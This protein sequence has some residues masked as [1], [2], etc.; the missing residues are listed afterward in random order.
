MN[1]YHVA[2]GR[3]IDGFDVLD[4]IESYGTIQG[5]GAQKGETT[6]EIKIFDCGEL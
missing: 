2:F 5:Y 1:G 4:K 3:L 6:K